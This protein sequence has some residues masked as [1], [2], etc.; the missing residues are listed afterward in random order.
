[1]ASTL[2]LIEYYLPSLIKNETDKVTGNT[3]GLTSEECTQP[4]G[5]D[6]F[7]HENIGTLAQELKDINRKNITITYNYKNLY[8]KTH[9]FIV[10]MFE[11]FSPVILSIF[12]IYYLYDYLSCMK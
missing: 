7:K 9:D 4:N 3:L 11:F 8:I 10:I 5:D 1:M 12:G 6:C 2:E